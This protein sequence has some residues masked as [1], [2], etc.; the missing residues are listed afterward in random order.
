M[1][2]GSRS[3]TPHLYLGRKAAMSAKRNLLVRVPTGEFSYTYRNETDEELL[4]RYDFLEVRLQDIR[5]SI[6]YYDQPMG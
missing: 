4:Q 5:F 3:A 6:Q 1:E 2:G